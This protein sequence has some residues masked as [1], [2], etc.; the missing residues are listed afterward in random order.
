MRA[1]GGPFGVRRRANTNA[2][3]TPESSPHDI[4]AGRSCILPSAR[5]AKSSL[6]WI[7]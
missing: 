4:L 7:S 5:K 3:A 1:A 2:N 6:T